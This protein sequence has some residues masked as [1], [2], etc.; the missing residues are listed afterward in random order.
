MD[1]DT[2]PAPP[3]LISGEI[4]LRPNPAHRH[5][6]HKFEMARVEAERDMD[7]PTGVRAH[8]AAM[9][10]VVLYVAARGFIAGVGIVEL[11]EDVTTR[12]SNHVGQDVEAPAMRHPH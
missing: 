4:L 12:L 9:A 7:G 1:Q 6:I 3:R 5:R 10:Q 8:V 2:D 11:A